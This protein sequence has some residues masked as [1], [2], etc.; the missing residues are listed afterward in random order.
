MARRVALAVS[1]A[2]LAILLAA[3]AAPA[4]Q[5]KRGGVLRIAD[6]ATA[7][8]VKYTVRIT[9]KEPFT[10]FL[11]N[12]PGAVARRLARGRALAHRVLLDPR[13]KRS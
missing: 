5:P 7:D 4:Q 6:F 8:D 12:H 11:N 13:L 10:P 2:L 1:L 9:L 3:P